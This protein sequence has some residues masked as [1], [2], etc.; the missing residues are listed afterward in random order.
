MDIKDLK[1]EII[2]AYGIKVYQD[3]KY[4]KFGVDAFCLA[5]FTREFIKKKYDYIDLCSGTGIVGILTSKMLSIP[6]PIF[7]EINPYFVKIN[8][9]NLEMNDI[10]GK[11]YNE[12]LAR[13]GEHCPRESIDFM[14]INPPYML[15]NRGLKTRDTNIDLAKIERDDAFLEDVFSIAHKILRDKGQLFMVH[16]VERLADI[17]Y[18]S[19]IHKMEAKTIQYIRN[20]GSSKAS[21]V[22][23]RFVK[24][25]NRFLN[26]LDDYII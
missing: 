17:F 10:E 22:L 15:P 6:N 21:L 16:R 13:L 7:V 3:P 26:N 23:I 14:T 25:S 2:E 1:L 4:F 8:E 19:R 9:K 5:N 18:Q 11:V 20:K 24:N 12:D